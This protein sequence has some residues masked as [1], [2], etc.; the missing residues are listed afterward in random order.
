MLPEFNRDTRH[1]FLT[2]FMGS[3]KT[4]IGIKLA[5]KLNRLFY[6]C[7]SEIEKRSNWSIPE[8]FARQG[9][10][11]FRIYE[12]EIVTELAGQLTESVIALGGGALIEPRNQEVVKKHGW[13]IYLKVPPDLLWQRVRS[14]RNRPLL[15][16]GH[17][18]VAREEFDQ[19]AA[20]LMK[21]RAE[22][23]SRADF[24]IDCGPKQIDYIVD[25]I[26]IELKSVAE[27][28]DI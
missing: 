4:T 3:G 20:D 12:Q 28:Q 18:V 10:Q 13:L 21:V 9:E 15:I 22:G 26:L 7:D 19:L 6:D 23:Y 25:L 14:N 8:I 16:K 27:A 17:A 2:G 24:V 11:Q 1:I 5:R